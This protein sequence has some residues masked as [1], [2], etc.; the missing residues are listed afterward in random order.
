MYK[1]TLIPPTY[2]LPRPRN[3]PSISPTFLD[4][5]R[6]QL[7]ADKAP[8]PPSRCKPPPPR[9][10]MAPRRPQDEQLESRA[11]R[12]SLCSRPPESPAGRLTRSGGGWMSFPP[13]TR[14]QPRGSGLPQD[15]RSVH[16]D[17]RPAAPSRITTATS[18]SMG[19]CLAFFGDD[20]LLADADEIVR[21][22]S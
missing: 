8:P 18:A 3:P 21:S 11:S 5:H 2:Y 12:S 14:P 16:T 9:P 6:R 22:A 4:E 19:V 7:L 1:Y 17:V 15:W 13:E 10:A 20:V